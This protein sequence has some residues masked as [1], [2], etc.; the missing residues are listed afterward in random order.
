MPVNL[1]K[2]KIYNIPNKL[3]EDLAYL[4]GLLIGDGTLTYKH[5]Y[6]FSSNDEFLKNEFYNI[7][8]ELFNYNVKSKKLD[9]SEHYVSSHFLRD[10]LYFLGLDYSKAHQKRIPNKIL[11]APKNIIKAFLQGLFDSDG[12][13]DNRYGNVS[14]STS[15]VKLA[16]QIHILLLN[17]G[18]ISTLRTKKTA[19]RP[20]YNIDL[21]GED[22][23]RFY[24]EIGFRLPRKSERKRLIS[25]KRMTNINSIPYL[26]KILKIIQKNQ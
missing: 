22:S 4:M 11:K 16:S 15:S 8:R 14:Y 25:K 12:T 9:K 24:H 3:I 2:V 17:F 19:V 13:A 23:I 21:Y 5:S 10:F 26:N 18:I 7:N 20:N 1:D 6:S